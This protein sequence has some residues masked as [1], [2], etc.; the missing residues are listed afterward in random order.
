MEALPGAAVAV[1]IILFF[2]TWFYLSKRRHDKL[3]QD[4]ARKRT[5]EGFDEFAASLRGIDL[6]V[7]QVVYRHFQ[8]WIRD[9]NFPVRASD[10]YVDT[11]AMDPLDTPG[12]IE[13][14]IAKCKCRKTTDFSGPINTVGDLARL[15]SSLK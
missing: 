4:L 14:L 9:P 11:F 1:V 10:N 12:L 5:G 13:E 8:D 6:E 7:L 2:A 15:L 3:V